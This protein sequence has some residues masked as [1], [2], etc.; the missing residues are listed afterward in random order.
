ME[1]LVAE[2]LR[3]GVEVVGQEYVVARMGW[4]GA[5]REAEASE[6]GPGQEI[7]KVEGETEES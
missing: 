5:A 7:E 3:V 1:D 4:G 6:A 2:A